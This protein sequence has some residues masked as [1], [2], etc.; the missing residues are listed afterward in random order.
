MLIITRA[1]SATDEE[2][3][4]NAKHAL[5][6]IPDLLNIN[7]FAYLSVASIIA[8]KQVPHPIFGEEMIKPFPEG[9]PFAF[10]GRDGI[11]A[12][13]QC[14]EVNALEAAIDETRFQ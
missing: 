7:L 8:H 10:S 4:L 14:K 1:D 5:S 9:H 2:N 13:N 11:L 6:R 3:L 12:Y